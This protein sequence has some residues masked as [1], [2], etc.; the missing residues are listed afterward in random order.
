MK[1]DYAH[2]FNEWWERDVSAMVLRDRNHPSIVDR[3]GLGTRFRT[4]GGRRRRAPLAK[5]IAGRVRALDTTR[6]LTL[7][8]P[9]ATYTANTDAV[10]SQ[11]DITG[12]NYNL[13]PNSGKDHARVP[14][15]IMMT[16]ESMPAVAFSCGS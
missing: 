13:V 2:E 12:Y 16:T 6:P 9:G 11:L 7:A 5:Q 10:F 4:G 8:F 14:G 3:G 15:R 1:F